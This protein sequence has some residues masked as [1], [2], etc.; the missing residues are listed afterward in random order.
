MPE[1]QLFSSAHHDLLV[2]Q[3][4]LVDIRDA[5]ADLMDAS[6]QTEIEVDVHE[7]SRALFDLYYKALQV[8]SLF[9][10]W[11]EEVLQGPLSREESVPDAIAGRG[12]SLLSTSPTRPWSDPGASSP[13]VPPKHTLTHLCSICLRDPLNYS[14]PALALRVRNGH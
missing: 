11:H 5:A 7:V 3:E 6:E 8:Y 9:V 14:A 2:L 13:F 12:L 4:S 1:P 10:L